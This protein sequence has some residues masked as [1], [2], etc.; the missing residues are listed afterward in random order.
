M[1]WLRHRAERSKQAPW[2]QPF[3]PPPAASSVTINP[4]VKTAAVLAGVTE[5]GDPPTTH[6]AA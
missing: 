3:G 4:M 6:I 5:H 1:G 2:A